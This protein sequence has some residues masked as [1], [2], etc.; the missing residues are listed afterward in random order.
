M[1]TPMNQLTKGEICATRSPAKPFQVLRPTDSPIQSLPFGL[2]DICLITKA[3]CNLF[4]IYHINI[5]PQTS[6]HSMPRSATLPQ[7]TTVTTAESSGSLATADPGRP[8]GRDSGRFSHLN[9]KCQDNQPSP[10]Q[11]CRLRPNKELRCK[12][13]QEEEM[14][15]E[16][17]SRGTQGLGILLNKNFQT[18]TNLVLKR[19]SCD[20]PGK[21]FEKRR[22]SAR[23]FNRS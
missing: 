1:K 8:R 12:G 20:W 5:L 7:S 13:S 19:S 18:N 23:I 9:A 17:P 15:G 21:T 11:V 3:M 6:S 10:H 22:L 14:P 4:L 2:S 16:M